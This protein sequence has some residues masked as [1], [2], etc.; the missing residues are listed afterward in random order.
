[1]FF[2]TGSNRREQGRC[3]RCD[4]ISRWRALV[5]VVGEVKPDWKRCSIHESS[6]SDPTLSWFHSRCPGYV[7]TQYFPG[8]EHGKVHGGFRCEDL[9]DQTFS[10]AQFDLVIT[11]DVLEHLPDPVAGLREIDRTLKPDGVH[12]FTLPRYRG[13]PTRLR[14]RFHPDGRVEHLLAPQYHGNPVDPEGS[15]VVTDWGDDVAELI[16]AACGMSTTIFRLEDPQHGIL[17]GVE[18]FVSRKSAATSRLDLRAVKA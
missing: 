12:V 6:A 13:I 17:G 2:C 4:S 16:H 3:V 8:V 14:A 10:D 15:L 1:M 9:G 18:I 5:H 7:A 11:Q